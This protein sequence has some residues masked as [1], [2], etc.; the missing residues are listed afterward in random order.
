MTSMSVE[1][2]HKIYF[3]L[4]IRIVLSS[5]FRFWDLLNRSLS[6]MCDVLSK[7]LKSNKNV[8]VWLLNSTSCISLLP[9]SSRDND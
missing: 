9:E 1:T 8:P 6:F 7:V 3:V 5:G 2:A 4:H